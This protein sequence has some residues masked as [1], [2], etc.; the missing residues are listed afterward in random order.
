[1]QLVKSSVGRCITG[2]SASLPVATENV[3]YPRACGA[4]L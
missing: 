1:M 2:V 3:T 4:L